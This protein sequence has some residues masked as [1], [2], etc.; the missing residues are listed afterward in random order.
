MQ[1]TPLAMALPLLAA[2]VVIVWGGG[3]GVI[4]IVLNET[5]AGVWGAI[6]I[7]MALVLGVPALAA[8]HRPILD[9]IGPPVEALVR[10]MVEVAELISASLKRPSM[11]MILPLLAALV[12]IVWGGGVGVVFI[13]L[14]E[15]GAGVW[16]AII[17]GMALVLGIPSVAALLAVSRR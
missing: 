14:N 12:I 5:G 4:F 2:L 13:V 3:I 15:T 16:G 7:G 10:P 6:I 11:A 1:R 17:I 8:M 9:T